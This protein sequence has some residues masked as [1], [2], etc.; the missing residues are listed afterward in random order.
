MGVV[1]L[2]AAAIIIAVSVISNSAHI[3]PTSS[4]SAFGYH[5][6]GSTGILL[7]HGVILGAI[8][9]LGLSLILAGARRSSR[10]GA[11]AR[12]DLK[13]SH[14]HGENL[15]HAHDEAAADENIAPSPGTPHRDIP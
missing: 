13:Q 3:L 11:L 14:Q 9:M 2:L 5:V 6:T 12:R 7:L 8:A 15:N 10:R 4:F 1:I